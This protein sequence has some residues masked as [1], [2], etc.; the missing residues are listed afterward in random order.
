MTKIL[1]DSWNGRSG[2]EYQAVYFEPFGDAW[3]VH[4]YNSGPSG[5]EFFGKEDNEWWIDIAP[6]EHFKFTE[7]L[8]KK[9]MN[10]TVSISLASMKGELKD[11][12]IRYDGGCW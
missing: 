6:S 1:S 4:E 11:E 8:L 5:V 9:V 3:R 7:Y 12:G 2:R 10:G